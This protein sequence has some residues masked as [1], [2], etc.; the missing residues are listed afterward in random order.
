MSSMQS[1]KRLSLR[2]GRAKAIA[3]KRS[4]EDRQVLPQHTTKQFLERL[5]LVRSHEL[6]DTPP[7]ILVPFQPQVAAAPVWAQLTRP[8]LCGRV[9]SQTGPAPGTSVPGRCLGRQS[10]RGGSVSAAAAPLSH[11]LWRQFGDGSSVP[12]AVAAIRRQLLPFAVRGGS[13]FHCLGRQNL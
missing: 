7:E 13:F 5:Q 11:R 8:G 9:D 10:E 6:W 2:C 1:Q 3:T 12:L 4:R